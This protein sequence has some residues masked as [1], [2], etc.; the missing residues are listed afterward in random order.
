MCEL[1]TLRSVQAQKHT[2]PSIQSIVQIDREHC[3]QISIN[4]MHAHGQRFTHQPLNPVLKGGS[5]GAKEAA[6]V[7][8]G[9][10]SYNSHERCALMVEAG[11]IQTLVHTCAEGRNDGIWE[12]DRGNSTDEYCFQ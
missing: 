2:A 4:V 8:L 5:D 3:R 11:V 7:A 12:V 9:H 1:S 6:V 10:L